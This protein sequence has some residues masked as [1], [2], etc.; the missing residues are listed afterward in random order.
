MHF[1]MHT[2]LLCGCKYSSLLKPELPQSKQYLLCN[3]CNLILYLQII[4]DAYIQDWAEDDHVDGNWRILGFSFKLGP[5]KIRI[6]LRSD[7]FNPKRD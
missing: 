2:I 3:E 1:D 5:L 6:L 4:F 7:H